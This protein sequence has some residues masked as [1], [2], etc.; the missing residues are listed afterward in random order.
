GGYFPPILGSASRMNEPL[1]DLVFEEGMTV[2]VQPN[3]ITPDER[4]GV[5]TGGLVL[6]TRD[7][8]EQL[9]H[10]PRGFW[11]AG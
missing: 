5:Q 1:P 11:R 4:A 10:A 8:V 2:V 9:Q 7:G 6:V 3:V